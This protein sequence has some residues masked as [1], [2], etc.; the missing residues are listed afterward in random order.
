MIQVYLKNI[1]ISPTTQDYGETMAILYSI[2]KALILPSLYL[3]TS[4]VHIPRT[5]IPVWWNQET[6]ILHLYKESFIGCV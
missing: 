1:A 5:Y 6:G 4:N 3:Q 2:P